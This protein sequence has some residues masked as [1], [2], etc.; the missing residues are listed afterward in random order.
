MG[1]N[2]RR[3]RGLLCIFAFWIVSLSVGAQTQETST[4]VPP[5]IVQA[6][7]ENQLTVLKGNTHGLAR[8]EFDQ[9][10]APPDL[11]MERMLLVLKR[12]PEQEAALSKLLDDQQDKASLNYHKWLTPEQFGKQFGPGRSGHADG[13]FVAAVSRIPYRKCGQG[14]EHH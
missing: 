5:R 8:T 12:S 2:A 9:G 3:V 11:P 7:D 10:A 4:Y 14:P 1:S 13:D 6:L